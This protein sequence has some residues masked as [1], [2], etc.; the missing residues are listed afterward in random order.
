MTQRNSLPKRAGTAIRMCAI[1]ALGLFGVAVCYAQSAANE[2][3]TLA[4]S[5][6]TQQTVG[7]SAP[8]STPTQNVPALTLRRAIELALQNSKDLQLA[9]IQSRLSDHS[10]LITKA[11]FMPNL[12]A[13]SGAGYTNGIPET[14][15]GRAPAIF[16]VT[17]GQQV[18]NEP[19]RGQAKEL[20][21]QA[22]S[23]KIALEEV[24]DSVI[25][26]TAMA[27]LELG[28]VRHSLELLRAE[29][30]SAEKI[31]QVTAGR[32]TEGFELS[33][34]VT[35]A[36]LTKAQVVQRILQLEG[37]QDELEVFLRAQIGLPQ[38]SPI[39]V[40]PEDLP[41]Q[42]EQE[43]ANLVA[44]ALQ[45]NT[46][47]RLAESD[48][49]AKEFRLKGE[50]RGYFPTLELVSIYSL[51]GRFN[52]YDQ[53]FKTFQRNNFNAGVQVTVPLFSAKTKANI[54][55]ADVNLEASKASLS[56]KKIEVTADV[57]QKT[58]SVREKDAAK[59]VAR[60]ELQLAQQDVAVFQ[61]QYAEGKLNLREV[62]KAR[63]SENERWM[64]YLDA[65]FAR[66]QAQLELL[67]VAG[68]LNKVWQ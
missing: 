58:R 16:N 41:G 43:G 67:R 24:R 5:N 54:G 4:I 11:E 2:R 21:E 15:G 45:D 63:L 27:F 34:E 37:R 65:N 1:V 19:L 51:L 64:A 12:Y 18:L 29:R 60:L 26:R 14:P 59:E 31:L 32:Q 61:S 68:Q 57:R 66:Q 56:N 50:K 48:V 3:T 44:M 30:E 25:V 22:R 47:V 62:E 13:G 55:L 42:A 9:K 7:D 20:Q 40:L 23:Q 52:N 28:K 10:A 8:Q 38:D 53:F 39:E 33:I 36:Q 17:Y 35:R 46:S 6:R 49:R